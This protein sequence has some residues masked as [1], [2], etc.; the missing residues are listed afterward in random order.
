[1]KTNKPALIDDR[2]FPF[3][4]SDSYG[5]DD[6][7]RILHWHREIEICYIKNGNG[8]YL[9]NGITYNFSKSD[10]FIIS[11]NDIHLCYDENDLVMQVI[12]FD[13]SFI[14]AESDVLINFEYNS[15]F[16]GTS[17]KI[18][19]DHPYKDI[20]IS[21]LSEIE[22][23]YINQPDVFQIMIKALLLQFI[24]L[25]VRGLKNSE[26][27]NKT[28]IVSNSG[29]IIVRRVIQYIEKNYSQDISLEHISQKYN[30]S[31]SYL[32]SCFKRLTGFSPISYLIQ[33]RITESKRLLAM[34]DKS[35]LEISQEC[36]F[37]SLSN[38]NHLFKENSGCSPREYRKRHASL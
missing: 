34:T 31:I 36:G 10:I 14:Q 22:N 11:N 35:V 37:R 24:T 5:V 13:P 4:C 20:L 25:S 21:L 1:M 33:K 6:N 32:S 23:E 16:F 9:I 26:D 18:S 15:L 17:K 29:A 8:K 12:M 27:N 3:E 19:A 7:F 28:L 2:S 30:V 38:F